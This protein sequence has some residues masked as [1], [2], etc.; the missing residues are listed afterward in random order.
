MFIWVS[1]PCIVRP[2]LLFLEVRKLIKWKTAQKYSSILTAPYKMSPTITFPTVTF[3]AL[4]FIYFPFVI[5][6]KIHCL[7]KFTFMTGKTVILRGNIWITTSGKYVLYMYIS[8]PRAP[9]LITADMLLMS[10]AQVSLIC[11]R[12]TLLAPSWHRY[13]SKVCFL[14]FEARSPVLNISMEE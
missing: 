5:P 9:S 1:F 3:H 11:G 4:H 8:S 13:R 12:I 6:L 10:L 2:F 7:L 14:T